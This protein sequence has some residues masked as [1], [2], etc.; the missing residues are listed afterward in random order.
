MLPAVS[1]DMSPEGIAETRKAQTWLGLHQQCHGGSEE[2]NLVDFFILL[3]LYEAYRHHSRHSSKQQQS[4]LC[5]GGGWH[6]SYTG[7][8]DLG[9]TWCSLSPHGHCLSQ[10]Q[11][12]RSNE[13]LKKT[14]TSKCINKHASS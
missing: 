11:Q 5:R 1:W 4:R 2:G 14:K 8:G 9:Y 13:N 12:P 3:T 10:C 7:S 6:R